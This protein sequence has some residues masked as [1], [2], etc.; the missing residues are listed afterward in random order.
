MEDTKTCPACDTENAPELH[1]C[2][3][4]GAPLDQYALD[5]QVQRAT[6]EA[7]KHALHR[8]EIWI[9]AAVL[10]VGFITVKA[11][12][13]GKTASRQETETFYKA[14]IDVD[15][16]EYRAFWKC[17]QRNVGR[18]AN[19]MQ[20]NL[21]FQ[22]ALEEAFNKAAAQYPKFVLNVCLPRIRAFPERMKEIKSVDTLQPELDNYIRT[23]G[24]V[25]K[26]AE[27]YA[28]ELDALNQQ[29]T[30][31]AKIDEIG[32][33][34]HGD[35][36]DSPVTMAYDHFL[37][38]A[39]PDYDNKADLQGIV[40]YLASILKD[41][42]PQTAHWRKDCEPLL[43]KTDEVKPHAN[44]KVMVKKLGTD[45]REIQA[46]HSLFEKADRNTRQDIMSEMGKAWTE[47]FNGWQSLK[48]KLGQVLGSG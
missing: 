23:A 18:P 41:P 11:L 5:Q 24:T 12:T 28:N 6:V 4:C 36:K 29:A 13:G 42:N 32:E 14:F 47:Y 38:C 8:K 20:D 22:R 39:I 31:D 1:T 9:G 45:D 7:K 21:E 46:F 2:S 35:A 16:K 34:F 3:A 27:R 37:R 19:T 43:G 25:A 30:A 33:H 48:A 44:Y 26:A 15:E 10:V 17:V 40:E